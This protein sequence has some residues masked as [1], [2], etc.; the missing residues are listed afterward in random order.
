MANVVKDKFKEGAIYY[1]IQYRYNRKDEIV[2]VKIYWKCVKRN[3]STGYISFARLYSPTMEEMN[4]V[5][6]KVENF[7]DYKDYKRQNGYEQICVGHGRDRWA[8]S[9][10]ICANHIV[11]NV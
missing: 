3:P 5:S 7:W 11:K 9:D 6:R 4:R 2:P 1:S 10:L 8:N